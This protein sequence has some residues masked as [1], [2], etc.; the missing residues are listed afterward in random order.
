MG[1]QKI[2]TGTPGF[3][4]VLKG[5]VRKDSTILITGA[6]GTGKTLLALQFLCNGVKD[7][8]ENGI[9]ITAE[10]TP[11]SL[12][13]YAEGVGLDLAAYEKQGKVLIIEKPVTY[14]RGGISSIRGLINIIKQRKVKRMVL[15]SL[16]FFEYLYPKN[17][18]DDI[19][20]R[21]Q[22]LQFTQEMKKEGIT[23]MA[24]AER[25]STDLDKFNFLMMDFLFDAFVL[26]FRVR[27][28]S[29]YERCMSVIKV[30]GQEHSLDIYPVSIG[31]GGVKVLYDQVPFSLVEEEEKKKRF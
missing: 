5:G 15:D 22:V 10:E 6:P 18:Y 8:N 30:K 17:K 14:L 16:T 25:A 24:T 26:L 27:K 12:K 29:Y 7:H 1:V 2:S 11:E 13:S 19:D 9:I 4:H 20:F 31:G 28:G 23:L 21:R 3:D